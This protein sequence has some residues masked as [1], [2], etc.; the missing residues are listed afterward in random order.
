MRYY[1]TIKSLQVLVVGKRTVHDESFYLSGDWME[2]KLEGP[3]RVERWPEVKL[4]WAMEASPLWPRC[5]AGGN[6]L[7]NKINGDGN[8]RRRGG[9]LS[10]FFV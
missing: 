6:T 3:D 4:L 9:G 1:A 7:T 5:P 2:P 8:F 10:N